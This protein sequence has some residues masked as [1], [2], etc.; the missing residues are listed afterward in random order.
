MNHWQHNAMLNLEMK[1]LSLI[2]YENKIIKNII[3]MLINQDQNIYS[4]IY[5]LL[6]T[7][8]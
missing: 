3:Y 7:V 5:K 8:Y 6:T 4:C 2:N 1:N